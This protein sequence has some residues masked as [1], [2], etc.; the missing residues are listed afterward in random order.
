M[1]KVEFNKS[2]KMGL[3]LSSEI[4]YVKGVGPEVAKLFKNLG[5]KVVEDLLTLSPRRYAEKVFIKDIQ[6]VQN[7]QNIKDIKDIQDI[8]PENLSDLQSGKEV[9]ISGRIIETGIKYTGSGKLFV[10]KISDGTGVISCVFFHY[11]PKMRERFKWGLT[12]SAEGTVSNWGWDLQ[13]INPDISLAVSDEKD[14]YLPVYPLTGWLTHSRIRKI[15]RAILDT[16]I[17]IP[18]TLPAY[19]IEE[20]H[21]L[22]RET[23]IRNLHFPPNIEYVKSVRERL[24]FEELFLLEIMVALRKREIQNNGIKFQKGSI[25]ARKFFNLLTSEKPGFN[26][27]KAQTRVCW[28]IFTDMESDKKMNRLLQ[29]DVGSGKTIVAIL[30][31]LKAIESGYQAILMAPTEILAEQHYF[32][33]NQY[34]SKIGVES[35]LLMGKTPKKARDKIL[36]DIKSGKSQIIIGTHALIEGKVEFKNPGL[37]VIDEQHKFGVAQRSKLMEKGTLP[38]TLVLTATPIPRSLSLIFYGNLDI[39]IID[40]LPPGVKPITTKWKYENEIE[41]VWKFVISELLIGHQAYIVYPIIEESEKL[42]LK[43]A[44]EAYEMLKETAFKNFKVGLLHG[45]M[46][47]DEKARV[48]ED[49]RKGEI[50]VLVATT[51]IEVGID[52]PNASCMVIE[53]SERFGLAQ[54]HQLRGRLNRGSKKSYCILVSPENISE[55]SRERLMTIEQESDGFKLSE[56]DLALRGPGDFLG[57]MQHG[58]PEFKFANLTNIKFISEVKDIAFGIIEKDPLLKNPQNE[59][60]AKALKTTYADKAKFL[61]AG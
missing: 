55:L 11:S 14:K 53:H 56:K 46:K 3:S 16:K 42:D 10:V 45:R 58:F 31:M 1:E 43:A 24:G 2:I 40:E 4:Q 49:F 25:L 15:I 57:T 54:L 38:D 23:A 18:E 35:S 17:E 48:M 9:R 50:Q 26:L 6:N 61:T 51:I 37:I 13:L 36:E 52:V 28:E 41:E 47:S 20:R 27:T 12:V 34:L 32:C 7:I 29:G 60:I 19:L 21:L 39:S 59:P 22:S 44:Q 30:A 8:K 33:L 5:I